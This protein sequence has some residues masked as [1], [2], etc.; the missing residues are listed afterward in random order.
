MF[1]CSNCNIYQLSWVHRSHWYL[2][3]ELKYKKFKILETHGYRRNQTEFRN[4]THLNRLDLV[5][6]LAEHWTSK[7]KVAGSIPTVVSRLF[8][9]PGVDTLRDNITN[10]EL[11]CVLVSNVNSN[12]VLILNF[13]AKLN[14]NSSRFLP[15]VLLVTVR[16]IPGNSVVRSVATLISYSVSGVNVCMSNIGETPGRRTE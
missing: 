7:P 6:Q 16:K 4:I 8:S 10:M 12:R 2:E 3:N 11:N 1:S 15:N 14:L 13:N 5:V 9:L